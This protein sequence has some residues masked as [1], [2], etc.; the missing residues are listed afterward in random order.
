MEEKDTLFVQILNVLISTIP[1][2]VSMVMINPNAIWEGSI[3][4]VLLSPII[5][6]ILKYFLVKMKMSQSFEYKIM[7]EDGFEHQ[8]KIFSFFKEF[9]NSTHE[10]G[11]DMFDNVVMRGNDVEI[12]T[13]SNNIT[14][15]MTDENIKIL[16]KKASYDENLI[17]GIKGQSF[18]FSK[19][20][21]HN[22]LPSVFIHGKNSLYVKMLIELIVKTKSIINSRKEYQ[23]IKDG[24]VSNDD[25][26]SIPF[27]RLF[28]SKHSQLKYMADKWRESKE[29]Y[30]SKYIPHK[31]VFLLHG[32]PGSG[33]TTFAKVL[34]SYIGF[35]YT[36]FRFS[37][38]AKS[39]D[40]MLSRIRFLKKTVVLI[41]EF[42]RIIENLQKGDN[43]AI[44]FINTMMAFLENPNLDETIII[45]TTNKEPR[46]FDQALIRPGRVDYIEEFGK[47]TSEQFNDIF[48]Y[49]TNTEVPPNFIFP[50]NL[51]SPSDIINKICIPFHN[52]IDKILQMVKDK[53]D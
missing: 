46:D 40:W 23:I 48:K 12:N 11:T 15:F 30:K 18:K 33:K 39:F 50:E 32:V 16:K 28:L 20:M 22:V 49:F 43:I 26:M 3:L 44:E 47:C 6:Q 35:S 5:T 41:D 25:F 31:K 24:N 42:D 19:T 7:V 2:V 4:V 1:G 52:D 51:H 13:E 36:E 14:I 8:G 38:N 53:Q 21:V 9:P 37:K 17:N 29:Y 34:S 10:E 27:E 45:L